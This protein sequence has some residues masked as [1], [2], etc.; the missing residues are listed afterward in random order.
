M[1]YPANAR[2]FNKTGFRLRRCRK[3]RL[4]GHHR[5][6]LQNTDAEFLPQAVEARQPEAGL[7]AAA[8]LKLR[9]HPLQHLIIPVLHLPKVDLEGE[10]ARQIDSPFEPF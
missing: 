3:V 2:A 6:R 5:L 10:T 4:A 7:V 1:I 8:G 9:P